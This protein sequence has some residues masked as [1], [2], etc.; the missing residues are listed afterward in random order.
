MRRKILLTVCLA[1]T[2]FNVSVQANAP[3]TA[4][5]NACADLQ[6]GDACSFTNHEGNNVNGACHFQSSS[7]QGTLICVP[8]QQ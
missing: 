4:E 5:I 3:S 7:N 2:I 8:L 6:S 1:L